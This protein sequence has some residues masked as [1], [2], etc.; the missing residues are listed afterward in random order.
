MQCVMQLYHQRVHELPSEALLQRE[1]MEKYSSCSTIIGVNLEA[2]SSIAAPSERRGV[3]CCVFTGGQWTQ[4]IHDGWMDR[5]VPTPRQLFHQD[6]QLVIV[7]CALDI[8]EHINSL[9]FSANCVLSFFPSVSLFV[10]WFS[11]FVFQ[12]SFS[13]CFYQ[14]TE[15]PLI[16]V[17]VQGSKSV[18]SFDVFFSRGSIPYVL[19]SQKPC[20]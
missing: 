13:V 16:I 18:H 14:K 4:T 17:A 8:N 19:S 1:I 9:M 3:L 6:S 2:E 12:S 5:E 15:T 20:F 7:P 11:F 10:S